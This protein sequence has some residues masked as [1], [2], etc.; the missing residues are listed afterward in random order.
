MD[1]APARKGP[2]T[3]PAGRIAS[4]AGMAALLLVAILAAVR[5]KLAPKHLAGRQAAELKSA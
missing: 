5:L 2:Q 1:E 4:V 3:S